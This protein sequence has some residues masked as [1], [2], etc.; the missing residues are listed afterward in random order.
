M[1]RELATQGIEVEALLVQRMVESGVEMLIGVVHD[2]LFGPVVVAG[3]GGTAVELLHDVSARITPL[4]DEDAREQLRSLKTYP[5][6]EGYRGAPRADIEAVEDVL[7]RIGR[8]VETHAEIAELDL[9]PVIATPDGVFVVDAR[10]RVEQ[11]QPR[12]PWPAIG[13]TPPALPPHVRD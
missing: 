1:V 9:N 8:M 4:T 5:L 10:V 13:S 2:P 6:L 12:A 11:S 3:A 7:L